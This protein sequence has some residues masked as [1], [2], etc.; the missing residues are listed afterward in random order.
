MSAARVILV[1]G[2]LGF[3]QL[4]PLRYFTDVDP[5]LRAPFDAAGIDVEITVSDPPPTSPIE[6][7]AARLIEQLAQLP[8]DAPLHLV[9]H[10]TG[11]I[12]CRIVL[13]PGISLPTDVDIEAVA[14]RI[15]SVVT[16]S[17]PHYGSPLARATT[18]LQAHR[19]IRVVAKLITTLLKVSGRTR[20]S[21]VGPATVALHLARLAG[22]EGA[23][24]APLRHAIAE[25][26]GE[27]PGQVE[28]EIAS[29]LDDVGGDSTLLE[30]LGPRAVARLRA[31]L[32]ERPGV[33][34]GSVVAKAPPP[35][36][37]SLASWNATP[38]DRASAAV[39]Q[40]IYRLTSSTRRSDVP[41]IDDAARRVLTKKYGTLP[42]HR[43]NDGLVPTRSQVWGEVVAAIEADHLDMMGFF[44][45][46]PGQPRLDMLASGSPFSGVDFDQT[47]RAI[48]EFMVRAMGK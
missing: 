22:L 4:G 41:P 34:I 10:S 32:R 20:I 38:Y 18:G 17:A 25:V 1:P 16:L 40:L 21:L 45:G 14:S 35:R 3:Q 37:L 28:P 39:Y 23:T 13:S 44:G 24:R 6:Q 2:L 48:G 7:R 33:C 42:D 46:R 8:G 47:W 27:H 31:D 43:D 12:D 15:A 36:L 30:Q 19:L 11:G 9:G 5:P 29:W 26:L